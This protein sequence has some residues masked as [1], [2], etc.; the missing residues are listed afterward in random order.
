MTRQDYVLIANVLRDCRLLDNRDT[1][2]MICVAFA[3][4]LSIGNASF[5]TEKFLRACGCQS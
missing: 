3:K 1:L 5:D 4:R 2:D